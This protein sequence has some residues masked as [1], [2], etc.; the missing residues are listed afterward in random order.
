MVIWNPVLVKYVL[1]NW[2]NVYESHDLFFCYTNP[3][4]LWHI[5]YQNWARFEYIVNVFS[6]QFQICLFIKFKKK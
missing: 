6:K 1:S 5:L 3:I 2:N 4:Q